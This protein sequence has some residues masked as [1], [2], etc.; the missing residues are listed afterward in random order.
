[1]FFGLFNIFIRICGIGSGPAR[2]R[3]GQAGWPCEGDYF[4]NFCI[5]V[6]TLLGFFSIS[7]S[8]TVITF[9]PSFFSA[10]MFRLSLAAF[11]NNLGFQYFLFVFGIFPSLQFL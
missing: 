11:F 3:Y 1:M 2:A 8:H 6:R 4:S 9:Q 10:A 5:L 7:H